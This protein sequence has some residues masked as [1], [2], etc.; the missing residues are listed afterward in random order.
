MKG[1]RSLAPA[2]IG[3]KTY[4]LMFSVNDNHLFVLFGT[5]NCDLNSYFVICKL[6]LKI[7][8]CYVPYETLCM[9]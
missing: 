8:V 6:S 2:G 4:F 9:T 5:K 1:L 7:M 3:L